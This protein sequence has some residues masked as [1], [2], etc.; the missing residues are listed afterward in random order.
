MDCAMTDGGTLEVGSDGVLSR[1][2]MKKV[3]IYH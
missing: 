1:E 3:I 2:L